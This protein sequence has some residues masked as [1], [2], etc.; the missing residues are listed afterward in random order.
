MATKIP[1]LFVFLILSVGCLSDSEAPSTTMQTVTTVPAPIPSTQIT[2]PKPEKQLEI[3][4]A[5]LIEENGKYLGEFTKNFTLR[6]EPEDAEVYLNGSK[7]NVTNGSIIL[8]VEKGGDYEIVVKKDEIEKVFPV[9][10]GHGEIK[11]KIVEVEPKVQS[12]KVKIFFEDGT[13]VK[14]RTILIFEE[15]ST[16]SGI[17][18]EGPYKI[19]SD[20]KSLVPYWCGAYTYNAMVRYIDS[21]T[22]KLLLTCYRDYDTSLG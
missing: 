4:L 18:R 5:F 7:L 10:I 16:V 20:E 15:F 17:R 12:P 2:S 8:S 19:V 21:V 9:F 13:L 6:V 11:A 1:F 14:N 22:G 3:S